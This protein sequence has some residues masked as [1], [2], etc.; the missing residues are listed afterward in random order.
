MNNYDCN[1]EIK[2]KNKINKL[3]ING[4]FAVEREETQKKKIK[5]FFIYQISSKY[6]N[7]FI[8]N[9]NSKKFFRVSSLS[10]AKRPNIKKKFRHKM[11]RLC[12]LNW[13]STFIIFF[14][15]TCI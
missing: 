7:L 10:T 12:S 14:F 1:L 2:V 15:D 6:Y 3:I 9:I 5:F 13:R 8:F 11:N 4:C